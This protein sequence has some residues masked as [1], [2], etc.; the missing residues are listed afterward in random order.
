MQLLTISDLTRPASELGP[1]IKRATQLGEMY[2][3]F[4]AADPGG[5]EY[6][7]D[8][9]GEG[10]RAAGLHASEISGCFRKVVYSLTNT[11]RW[12]DPATTNVGMKRRFRVG[13]A[14]HSM[15]QNDFHRMAAASNGALLFED[16]ARI[17]PEHQEL[18]KEWN[19]HS[20][21]DGI[22][23]FCDDG[24]PVMRVGVEI[25]TASAG[26][27]EKTNE[28]KKDHKEQTCLYMACLDVP[29]MWVLYYNKSN[30]NYTDCSPPYLS[31]FDAKLWETLEH[32]FANAHA[33]AD[34]ANATGVLPDREEGQPCG[35]CPFGH[36]CK[37]N[38]LKPRN[39]PV[40]IS[41]AL[42]PRKLK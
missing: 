14:L 10:G 9:G 37:P 38:Y 21:C 32:R 25:K 12:V 11:K 8:I 29:L 40:Q 28:P 26:E 39:A 27:Y 30:Q 31:K 20:S 33:L 15:L 18:A 19:I 7:V 5:F 22:F 23:T 2:D 36:E 16:E 41:R 35:W 4:L 17:S 42:T 1:L 13:N 24:V 3:T 34:V 6:S